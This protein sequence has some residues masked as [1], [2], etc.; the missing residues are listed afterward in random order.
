MRMLKNRRGFTLIE[1]VI[2]MAVLAILGGAIAGVLQTGLRSYSRISES[3]YTETEARTALSLVTVQIRQHDATDAI[4]V[5]AA[6]DIIRLKDD[7]AYDAGTVI[8]L[9]DGT[10]YCTQV[11][12]VGT[13]PEA[14]DA[15][16]IAQIYGIDLS[17]GVS[18][19]G[20]SLEYTVTIYYGEDGGK[21]LSQTITQRS[22]PA[23]TP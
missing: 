21:H 12:D 10:L 23:A 17:Q 6:N 3:M 2:A 13:I 18:G 15:E 8:W 19:S 4:T 9:E 1:L 11:S 7:P 16:A 20:T 5:D 22:A 14:D